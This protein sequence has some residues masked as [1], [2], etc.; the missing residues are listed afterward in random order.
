[1]ILGLSTGAFTTLHV[2]VSLA[3]ILSGLIIVAGASSW[4]P[5]LGADRHLGL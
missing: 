5:D 4:R 1:M 3:A 2:L